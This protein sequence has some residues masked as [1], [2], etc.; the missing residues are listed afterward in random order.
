MPGMLR[1]NYNLCHIG[2]IDKK[3]KPV[4]N[5]LSRNQ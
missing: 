1:K 2:I 3:N 5:L 4:R